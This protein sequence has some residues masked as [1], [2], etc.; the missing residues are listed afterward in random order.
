M[1]LQLLY[2]DKYW[3]S[4]LEF[5]L[6]HFQFIKM[7]HTFSHYFLWLSP[8]LKK[9]IFPQFL[10]VKMSY[11]CFFLEF[12]LIF[13]KTLTFTL[14]LYLM[15]H[16]LSSFHKRKSF[17]LTFSLFRW[18]IFSIPHSSSYLLFLSP[19]F[20]KKI[21]FSHFL[22]WLSWFFHSFSHFLSLSLSSDELLSEREGG[23]T[24]TWRQ[25]HGAACKG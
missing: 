5:S 2:L 21:I 17:S 22:E 4:S 10:F 24:M 18:F 13:L 19:E 25:P 11:W 1:W 16:W 7:F 23:G 15:F 9:N 8:K 3:C 14:N 12:S 20:L 6:N